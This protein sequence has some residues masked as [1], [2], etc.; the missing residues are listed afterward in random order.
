[1]AQVPTIKS[2][3][4]ARDH[5]EG[6][7]GTV[8]GD[9]QPLLNVC[10]AAPFAICREVFCYIDHLAHLYTGRD[11]V[12]DRF[13]DYLKQVMSSTDPN[14]SKRAGEIYQMYR[15]GPV[16]EFEPKVLENKR[17]QRLVWLCYNS[18]RRDNIEILGKNLT[19][20][21]LEPVESPTENTVFYLPVSTA[22]L[23]KDLV[24]SIDE[25]QK[26]GPEDERV[27]AWNRAARKLTE[28]IP[29]DFI[30]T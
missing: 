4:E 18:A 23:I 20:T 29:F 3:A 5:L 26:V 14:Y 12:G 9:V 25:F 2:W 17:G 21:H 11:Q 16:H 19:V 7:K 6:L 15:N 24:S 28:L 22:C 1:M 10:G 13:R 27:T 30:V 8:F